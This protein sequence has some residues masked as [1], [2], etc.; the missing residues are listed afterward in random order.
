M[1]KFLEEKGTNPKYYSDFVG[2]QLDKQQRQIN[3]ANYLNQLYARLAANNPNVPGTV[4]QNDNVSYNQAVQQQLNDIAN[5]HLFRSPEEAKEYIKSNQF[6][7]EYYSQVG[8]E[9]LDTAANSVAKRS[10]TKYNPQYDILLDKN[11]EAPEKP[12][13]SILV[14]NPTLLGSEALGSLWNEAKKSATGIGEFIGDGLDTLGI[15]TPD[16][17]KYQ[18]ELA[19]NT[20]AIDALGKDTWT[21]K[22]K[23]KSIEDLTKQNQDLMGQMALADPANA[24]A[25][26]RQIQNNTARINALSNSL[27]DA[28]KRSIDLYG[29]RYDQLMQER[30]NIQAYNP[31]RY[32]TVTRDDYER[33]LADKANKDRSLLTGGSGKLFEDW[34][35][36]K[37]WFTNRMSVNDIA[38]YVGEML[39]WALGGAEIG[40]GGL[41]GA[42]GKFLSSLGRLTLSTGK[43]PIA[44]AAF[45]TAVKDLGK[46]FTTVGG[47]SKNA[48]MGIA[49][50]GAGNQRATEALNEFF[51]REGTLEGFDEMKAY[52]MGMAEHFANFY[53]GKL[54]TGVAGKYSKQSLEKMLKSEASQ[55]FEAT[56]PMLLSANDKGLIA[57]TMLGNFMRTLSNP[58]EWGKILS[59]RSEVAAARLVNEG[60]NVQAA[61]T[62]AKGKVAHAVGTVTGTA[63]SNKSGYSI[64][65]M[66]EAGVNLAADNMLANIA[67]QQSTMKEGDK[68]DWEQVKEAG[69][70]GLLAGGF[71]HLG[72]QSAAY[73]K[74]GV[75]G[76]AGKISGKQYVDSQEV[77]D[78]KDASISELEKEE[79]YDELN[80]SLNSEIS[81]QDKRL[82]QIDKDILNQKQKLAKKYP[83]MF[84]FNADTGVITPIKDAKISYIAQKKYDV[85]KQYEDTRDSIEKR[86]NEFI[87][88]QKQIAKK[89]YLKDTESGFDSEVV[90]QQFDGIE[91]DTDGIAKV[92]DFDDSLSDAQAKRIWDS[93]KEN[94]V[95][96]AKDL[97]V[98]EGA[99]K[100][101]EIMGKSTT[102]LDDLA[103]HTDAQKALED[104][105]FTKFGSE[106]DK[107][108]SAN[109]T[110][111]NN[112]KANTQ[113]SE[114]EKTKQIKELEKQNKRLTK[115]KS[116]FTQK[117]YDKLSQKV[118]IQDELRDL[119]TLK[120]INPDYAHDLQSLNKAANTNLRQKDLDAIQKEWDNTKGNPTNLDNAADTF[121][122]NREQQDMTIKANSTDPL[123]KNEVT[124]TA[125][126][127][128]KAYKQFFNDLN[129]NIDAHNEIAASGV[130]N[131]ATKAEVEKELKSNKIEDLFEAREVQFKT[132]KGIVTKAY[133]KQKTIANSEEVNNL[134]SIGSQVSAGAS[135]TDIL[136][137]N[138]GATSKAL[139]DTLDKILKENSK[140]IRAMGYTSDKEFDVEKFL[141]LSVKQQKQLF[142]RVAQGAQANII[143]K[144]IDANKR[145][146]KIDKASKGTSIV[147]HFKTG[148]DSAKVRANNA[149]SAAQN[150]KRIKKAQEENRKNNLEESRLNLNDVVKLDNTQLAKNLIASLD[151]RLNI[152][153][154]G[155]SQTGGL[156]PLL[157]A[158][159]SSDPTAIRIFTIKQVG[160]KYNV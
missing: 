141:K 7:N 73:A 109:E 93:I 40:A 32:Q 139:R 110:S 18:R 127:Y 154:D 3:E 38:G 16:N 12:D 49:Y 121:A 34:E 107:I 35:Y 71:G 33:S 123:V 77:R 145:I 56:K 124:P 140:G 74:K 17:L 29:D 97:G 105:D 118:S 20:R 51:N 69:A 158:L 84:A 15:Y 134:N 44:K 129:A 43:S 5:N 10:Q 149:Y 47:L 42:S 117:E 148:F 126:E 61:L 159:N 116:T 90:R 25:I 113:L 98:S 13:D 131:R 122:Y 28:E 2:E 125:E 151:A 65:A 46:Q 31:S 22:N 114:D 80:S 27:T 68:I 138:A 45:T 55:L 8:E 36:T 83:E 26:Q 57:G 111:I 135:F 9:F 21:G 67:H 78:L 58:S 79:K 132:K 115:L 4:Y 130:Q 102:T 157:H 133:A 48:L 99:Y 104:R 11:V 101:A 156:Y 136:D 147:S 94:K 53:G 60:K 52:M 6:L 143:A 108:K 91:S 128:K 96:E 72:S 100:T 120:K 88:K 63:L 81:L 119:D 41:I 112:I 106:I 137:P 76:F 86:K 82:E 54:T 37:N 64:K 14:D 87:E 103:N 50:A 62:K 70:E 39:P 150:R 155:T 75:T 19:N 24:A 30:S 153:D 144:A 95:S 142:N 92:K 146:A 1:A 160:T 66:T 85:I 59:A 89:Q 152:W 23:I